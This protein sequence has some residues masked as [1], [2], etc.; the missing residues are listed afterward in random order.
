[1]MAEVMRSG[2]AAVLLLLA[3][4][5]ASGQPAPVFEVASVKPSTSQEV[6]IG[7]FVYPGGWLT[8]TNYTLKC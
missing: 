8:V 4:L 6:V 5:E 3:V 2:I 7:M 1:M